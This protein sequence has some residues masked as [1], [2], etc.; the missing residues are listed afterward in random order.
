MGKNKEI[1]SELSNPKILENL[2]GNPNWSWIWLV[3]RLYLGINWFKAGIA[4]VGNP[5]WTGEKAGVAVNGF[6]NG[7]LVK[8]TGEHPSVQAWYGWFVENLALP[9]AK[10]FSYLVAY[11]ELLVGIALILGIFTGLAAFF[12]GFMNL[13]YLLAGTVSTNP[14]MLVMA[15]L[16]MIAWRAAG[17]FG[18]DRWVIPK[19]FSKK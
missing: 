19:L 8:T 12:G 4:K 10:I 15:F 11:G 17:W 2:F 13:N 16:L 6:L 9:N 3:M 5:V 18:L 7:A 14:L 1:I